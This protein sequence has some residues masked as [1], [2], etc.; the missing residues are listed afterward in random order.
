M[1][2]LDAEANRTSFVDCR[3]PDPSM[4]ISSPVSDVQRRSASIPW[5]VL[6]FSSQRMLSFFFD[7][8]TRRIN[9]SLQR[10]RAVKLVRFQNL[11]AARPSGSPSRVTT[12]LECIRMPQLGVKPCTPFVACW[13]LLRFRS[14]R[15]LRADKTTLSCR[16][17]PEVG[18]PWLAGNSLAR[19]G[20]MTARILDSLI[21]R[22]QKSGRPPWCWPSPDMPKGVVAPTL[23]DNCF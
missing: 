6:R 15:Y 12:K 1:W 19:A 11:I 17:E 22:C 10:I 5:T 13:Y 20:K 9:P 3:S 23:C 16:E 4:C 7:R 14:M 2:C 8:H 18:K 21:V